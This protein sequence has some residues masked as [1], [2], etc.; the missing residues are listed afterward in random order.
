MPTPLSER[1]ERGM[2]PIHPECGHALM[3]AILPNVKAI[4]KK[5]TACQ[6]ECERAYDALRDAG[7]TVSG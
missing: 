7:V 4:E 6:E 1:I 3:T 2:V 5:L